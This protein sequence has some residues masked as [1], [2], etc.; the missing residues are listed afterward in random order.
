MKPINLF[1]TTKPIWTP[2]LG[3]ARSFFALSSLI[4]LL[5]NSTTDLFRPASGITDYPICVGWGEYSIFCLFSSVVGLEM[6]RWL[7]IA[8]LLLVIS[9]VYPRFTAPLQ[10]WIAYSIFNSSI[11]VDGGDQVTL[12]A[13]FLLLPMCL[14]DPRKNHWHE[15]DWKV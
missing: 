8:I 12:V 4:T 2:L 1:H 5:F 10:F 11:V 9:G 14:T 15:P 13:T 3:T 6:L 7:C